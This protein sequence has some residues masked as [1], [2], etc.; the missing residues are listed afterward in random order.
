MELSMALLK[1]IPDISSFEIH[2]DRK[3]SK[4]VQLISNYKDK[5]DFNGTLDSA[6]IQFLDNIGTTLFPV[7]SNKKLLDYLRKKYPNHFPTPNQTLPLA[8][9]IQRSEEYMIMSGRSAKKRKIIVL[10]DVYYFDLRT[11]K[12]LKIIPYNTSLG[13][14]SLETLKRFADHDKPIEILDSEQGALVF[15]PDLK[16]FK[17]KIDLFAIL[18]TFDFPIYDAASLKDAMNI[19]K[20]KTPRLVIIANLDTNIDSKEFLIE[21]EEFDPFVKKMNYTESPATNK[22]KEIERIRHHYEA[23]YK[24]IIAMLK[25]NDQKENLPEEIKLTIL[26]SIKELEENFSPMQFYEKAF[27]LKQF[28][29]YFNIKMYWNMMINLKQK[30]FK[31]R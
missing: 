22:K 26:N 17:L 3:D 6:H 4:L 11:G 2:Y 8:E 27:A 30:Y 19:Y 28:G 12:D 14:K 15:I 23:G 21:L 1:G 31:N 7:I 13:E 24:E 18:A 5:F 20:E 29:R 16:D 25:D 9:I 10:Q